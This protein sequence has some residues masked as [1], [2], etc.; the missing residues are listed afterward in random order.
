MNKTYYIKKAFK[1]SLTWASSF[2]EISVSKKSGKTRT[3]ETQKIFATIL[4]MVRRQPRCVCICVF[5][6]CVLL[7]MANI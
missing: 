4:N 7:V 3:N 2:G 1:I 6:N 5:K